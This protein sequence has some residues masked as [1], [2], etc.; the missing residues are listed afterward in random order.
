MTETQHRILW[1]DDD[2]DVIGIMTRPLEREGHRVEK[3]DKCEDAIR[4]LDDSVYDAIIL[5]IILP[6]DRW[7]RQF[8]TEHE[9]AYYG[10]DVLRYIRRSG[11][12]NY[13]TPVVVY[14]ALDEMNIR[15]FLDSNSSLAVSAVLQKPIRPSDLKKKI[16]TIIRDANK[17]VYHI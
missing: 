17:A 16:E 3:V 13:G 11:S 4:S 6:R 2:A 1:L 12:M 9:C 5:D 7:T 8:G 10:I 14:S 15:P